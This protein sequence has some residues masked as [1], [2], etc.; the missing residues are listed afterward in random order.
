MLLLGDRMRR[1]ITTV[2]LAAGALLTL[3]SCGTDGDTR[4]EPEAGKST[5]YKLRPDDQWRQS[6]NAAGITSW[7]DVSPS[8]EELIAMPKD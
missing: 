5:A 1:T 6:I 3:T 4:A 8:S 2:L 7:A